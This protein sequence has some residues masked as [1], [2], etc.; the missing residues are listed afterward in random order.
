[1]FESLG[2]RLQ[3]VFDDLQRYGKLTEDDVN[4][5]HASSSLGAA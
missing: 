1:M 3:T 4:V 2:N 5:A